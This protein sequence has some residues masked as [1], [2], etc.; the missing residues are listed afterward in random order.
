MIRFACTSCGSKFKVSDDKG[1]KRA[2][3]PR[4]ATAMT[5]PLPPPPQPQEIGEYRLAEEDGQPPP[6]PPQAPAARVRRAPSAA[7]EAPKPAGGRVVR[8]PSCIQPLPAESRICVDCGVKLPSGRPVLTSRGVD[9]DELEIKADKT[10]RPLSWLIPTGIYPLYSEALG[11]ARPW[12]TWTIAA[13]TIL[14]SIWF[15]A[16]EWSGSPQLRSAKN[17]MLWVGNAPPPPQRLLAL[18]LFT[19]YGDGDAFLAKVE[20]LQG[21][22]AKKTPPKP[23]KKPPLPGPPEE[24]EALSDEHVLAA[25]QALSPQ[26]QCLGQYRFSQLLT[27]AF[28]HGGLLHLAGNMLFLLVLGSRVNAAIGNLA[29]LVLYPF[30]AMVAGWAFQ[31]SAAAGLPMPLLGASGAVMGMAGMYVVLFPIHQIHMVAWWR[32]GLLLGAGLSKKIFALPGILVVLFYVS[33]DVIYTILRVETGVAHW[34][35]LG[36]MIAGIGLALLLLVSR[37]VHTGG[38]G[39]SLVLGKYAWGLVGTPQAHARRREG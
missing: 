17:L 39:L 26:Q 21:A 20:E 7:A 37:L 1:G 27:H 23:K 25:H 3:C 28:L 6:A 32:R 4:C 35:H 30:L 36:G 5:I 15:L 29:T 38:D 9:L 10:I 8:C 16:L 33:F 14:T 12:A 31:V 18:Y 34:A 13:I 2:K 24:E 11:R 19:S 22:V